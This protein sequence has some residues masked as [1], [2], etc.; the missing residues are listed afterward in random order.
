MERRK[1][2]HK[3]WNYSAELS[4]TLDPQTIFKNL[5]FTHIHLL[6]L[7]L[8]ME[9]KLPNKEILGAKNTEN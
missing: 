2:N 3:F 8:L 6:R 5:L 9:L 1:N 7:L 4:I